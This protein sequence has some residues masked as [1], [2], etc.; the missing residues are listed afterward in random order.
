MVEVADSAIARLSWC[1]MFCTFVLFSLESYC[2]LYIGYLSPIFG[3]PLFRLTLAAIQVELN[4]TDI[5][6]CLR[7][8][9]ET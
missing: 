9:N 5:F 8:R 7:L 6:D 4:I 3:A 2:V 1:F